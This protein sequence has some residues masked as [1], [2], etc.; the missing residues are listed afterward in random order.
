MR[1]GVLLTVLPVAVILAFPLSAGGDAEEKAECLNLMNAGGVCTEYTWLAMELAM[2]G[3]KWVAKRGPEDCSCV[4]W[5]T[6]G[7]VGFPPSRACLEHGKECECSHS[8][9]EDW[10]FGKRMKYHYCKARYDE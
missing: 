8:A 6:R 10:S 9:Y 1:A 3:S 4:L 7:G 2:E 5:E